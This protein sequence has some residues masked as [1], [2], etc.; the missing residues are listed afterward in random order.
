MAVI[1]NVHVVT[2]VARYR[3]ALFVR[4]RFC[5]PLLDSCNL[6]LNASFVLIHWGV[7]VPLCVGLDW[8]GDGKGKPDSLG[9]LPFE[10]ELI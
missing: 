6:V 10:S 3:P 5:V 1:L 4:C 9:L 8:D 7:D 2:T